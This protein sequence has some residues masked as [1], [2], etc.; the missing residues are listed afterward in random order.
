VPQLLSTVKKNLFL[1]L[2]TILKNS[3]EVSQVQAAKEVRDTTRDKSKDRYKYCLL[4]DWIAGVNKTA[5]KGSQVNTF[6]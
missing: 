2:S 6:S 1:K 3:W 4:E 5:G